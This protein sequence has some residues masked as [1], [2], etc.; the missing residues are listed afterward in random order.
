MAKANILG[1]IRAEHD[2]AMLETVFV[3][4]PDYRTLVETDDKIVVVGRRGTGKSALTNKLHRHWENLNQHSVI[5]IAP[6]EE[7][8]I[9]IRPSI[10]QLGEQVSHTRAAV[11]TLWQYALLME[12]VHKFHQNYKSRNSIA[13]SELLHRHNSAWTGDS[14][15]FF[16]LRT[17][18][19]LLEKQVPV[20][21]ERIAELAHFLEIK[22]IQKEVSRINSEYP[23][24]FCILIDRLDEGY[25]PDKVGVGIVDGVVYGT[26]D[27]IQGLSPNIRSVVF[28]RDNIYRAIEHWDQD[29]SR[30]IEGQVLRLHWDYHLLLNLVASR[31]R[32]VRKLDIDNNIRVWN[33]CTAN[34]LKEKSGFSKCLRLTLYRPRDILALLNEAFLSASRQNREEIVDEDIDAAAKAISRLRLSDL[35]KEYSAVFPGL[36]VVTQAFSGG[37]S[38]MYVEDALSRIENVLQSEISSS[39]AAQHLEILK[40]PTEV[41]RSLYSVGFVGL[42]EDTTGSYVFCHDGKHPD[43]EF[44]AEKRLLIH[45]CYAPALNLA[46]PEF[47]QN[48]A[49]EIFDEYEITVSSLTPEIRKAKLGQQIEKLKN[50][51][52]GD[53]HAGAFEEW[54]LETIRIAFANKLKNIQLHPNKNATLRRDIVATNYKGSELWERIYDDYKSRSIIFEIKNYEDIGVSEYRQVFG[55][56][57]R[58]YGKL[59][60]IICRDSDHLLKKG[61]EMNAFL[62]FYKHENSSIIIKITA[63]FLTDILSKLRNPQKH[64]AADHML[65]GLLDLYVRQYASA[66]PSK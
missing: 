48:E 21:E 16:K 36:E 29:F 19:K 47:E 2:G 46:D 1:D 35:H 25:E 38:R 5:L 53:E 31:L 65:K 58:E 3:E 30:N 40:S 23:R 27:L 22:A 52:S 50:I 56:L 57:G 55:Y 26:M 14:P 10:A 64:D 32:T 60:F 18:L 62:E 49:E 12:I 51:E 6:N 33:K 61:K 45:P 66:Q 34:G 39:P 59:A 20:A 42:H 15:I 7:D 4:T 13:S 63:K 41:L 37:T 9:G 43:K 17:K 11:K 54:C 28:L 24:K 44:V 8:V